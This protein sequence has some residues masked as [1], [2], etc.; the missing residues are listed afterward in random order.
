MV[1]LIG[2]FPEETIAQNAYYR[3]PL[4][5]SDSLGAFTYIDSLWFGLHPEATTCVD[6]SLG[7]FFVFTECGLF[8]QRCAQFS[9]P[10][11]APCNETNFPVILDLRRSWSPTQV[12][13]YLVSFI[14][15]DP[16]VMHWPNNL[17]VY[18]DS[19][20]LYDAA[21]FYFG[22]PHVID[23]D[24]LTVDSAIVSGPFDMWGVVI[25]ATG[26]QATTG[27]YEQSDESP[28]SWD[29]SQNYPNPFNPSTKFRLTLPHTSFVF[30]SVYNSMG[31][32]VTNLVN[33]MMEP[34]NHELVWSGLNQRGVLVGSG[35][36]VLRVYTLPQG[37]S[38]GISK[39][40]RMV[41]IR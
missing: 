6:N 11:G 15:T 21:S 38:N 1:V 34:G 36:Y 7:E 22:F 13:T 31:Q 35:V 37:G 41:L 17:S 5:L 16:I 18:Y 10:F 39:Q 32:E 27:L 30:A 24:M 4:W 12:D 25:L 20:R 2:W 14:G 28:S 29:L 26:P 33:S 19:C 8:S 9:R 23:I 3:F 40:R